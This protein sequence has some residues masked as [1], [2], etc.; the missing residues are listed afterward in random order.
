M[1]SV[2]CAAVV[3]CEPPS[4]SPLGFFN[5][6]CQSTFFLDDWSVLS[7]S[8]IPSSPACLSVC[9]SPLI[10]H[11]GSAPIKPGPYLEHK[12]NVLCSCSGYECVCARQWEGH[13]ESRFQFEMSPF[14]RCAVPV[15]SDDSEDGVKAHKRGEESQE[16][17]EFVFQYAPN[18]KF[19]IKSKSNI[20]V[21]DAH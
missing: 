1:S 12:A 21:R 4:Q 7:L 3:V 9:L 5:Q 20:T 6:L 13:T 14:C 10:R 11:A 18:V 17:P 16:G 2:C 19:F 8:S 15:P